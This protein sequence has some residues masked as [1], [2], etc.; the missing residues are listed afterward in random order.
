MCNKI[1]ATIIGMIL[2]VQMAFSAPFS[3]NAKTKRIPA[4]TVL[5]LKMLNNVGTSYNLKGN[6]FTAMLVTDQKSENSD[7]IIL[8]MGSI[9]R[10][11]I[12]DITPS[13]RFSRGA[14]LYLDFDHVVTPNGRQIP[15]SLAVTGRTDTTYDGGITTTKGYTD[16]WKQTCKKSGEITKK[17]VSWG[18]GLTDNG[19]KYVIVPFTAL[20]GALGTAGYFVYDS[21]ADAIRKGKDVNIDRNEI[22]NVT[23]IDPV[24]VPVI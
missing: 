3:G 1:F 7:E 4:G 2:T 20:G 13:K 18:E 14:V 8:P 17:A 22:L 24:D 6:E 5:S 12:K 11:S 10:G 23:L 21:V 16:A 9:V 19:F 15:L